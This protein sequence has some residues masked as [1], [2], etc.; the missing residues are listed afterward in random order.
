VPL[1]IFLQAYERDAAAMRPL[2]AFATFY[3][4]G[5]KVF[6][7]E[8]LGVDTWDAKSKAVPI[9]LSLSPNQLQLGQYDCQVTVLDPSSDRTAFWRASIT[10]IR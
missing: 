9:R 10:V 1:Y 5:A 2:V 4:D 7:T 3:R 8:P 6:E